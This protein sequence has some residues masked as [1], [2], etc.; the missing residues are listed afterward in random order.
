MITNVL[1]LLD[2]AAASHPDRTALADADVSYTY[3]TY[4]ERA[5]TLATEIIEAVAGRTGQPIAVAIGRN[6]DSVIRF[7]AVVYSGNAYVPLDFT[8]PGERVRK[9]L[10]TTRP[11]LVLAGADDLAKQPRISESYPLLDLQH[12]ATMPI[13]HERLDLI[14]RQSVDTDP[15]Y[16][17]FTSGSTGTPK[18]IVVSHRSV[19]DLI[20]RFNEVFEFTSDTIFGN[21]APFDFD[22][23]VKDIYNALYCGGCVR[24]IPQ[25]LFSMPLKLIAYLNEHRI[26]T[27]IWATSAL[28]IMEN[29]KALDADKPLY[30]RDLM[31]SGEIMPNK[32][33]NY[34]RAAL[35]DVRYVNL[36]GPT[37][38][39]CNCS[40]Y[41]VD[42][43][44]ADHEPLPIG[45][46]F[47]NTR[48]LLLDDE[49]QLVQAPGVRGELCVSGSSLALGYYRNEEQTTR[50]FTQN[51]LNRAYPEILYR[52]GDIAEYNERG[53]LM[54]CSRK[55]DQIKHMGH[56][57]EL[58]E[59]EQAV[60][61]LDYIQAS[62]CRYDAD[63]EKIY[64][65][66]LAEEDV[67][68]RIMKDL[69]TFLP[70]YMLPNVYRHC[71][72]FPLNKNNKID[73][74][75]IVHENR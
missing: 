70:K 58:G 34:W 23:S 57:I 36:Y 17:I 43:P 37:E 33:L 41:I 61:A 40:Y 75:R 66:S 45:V 14:R 44:F 53:E 60:N 31:F 15:L 26:N 12:T 71:R 22:V 38:I 59:I 21:Q 46:P 73:R 2:L 47:R 56:R 16:I 63:E 30:I 24:V 49:H 7:M 51:P 32:V 35:P 18:G 13:D 11:I 19:I 74:K 5:K 67:K 55:D 29:F 50:A 48:I 65:Y 28:R 39:T 6:A 42:R 10:D 62:F 8:Q 54:F 27:L 1:E 69:R 64:L 20:A 68:R 4:Q 25:T 52:T 9:I 72:E 3:R